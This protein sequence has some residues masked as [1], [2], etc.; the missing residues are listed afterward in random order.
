MRL[1]HDRND[2]PTL[3]KL[4]YVKELTSGVNPKRSRHS[5]L[6]HARENATMPKPLLTLLHVED[7]DGDAKFVQRAFAKE[8]EKDGCEITRVGSLSAAIQKLKKMSFDAILLD[9]NLNDIKGLSNVR[10]IKEENAEL[11]IVVLSGYDDNETALS[12]VRQGAQEYMVKGHSNSRMLGLAVLSSIERKIYERHLFKQANH[13]ELTGLPNRRMFLEYMERGIIRANRWKRIE[14]LMFLDV[15]GFKNVNDTLGHDIG[16]RLLE[17]IAARLKVGLRASDML[18][19][20]GGDEFVVHLDADAH[21]S[22]ETC[23][24]VAEKIIAM[25][26][27][28][29]SAGNHDIRTG[30]SIGIAF[31][32]EHGKDIAELIKSADH[33]MYQAKK[34]DAHIAFA[35]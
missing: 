12:A 5:I 9:L 21:T 27:D 18:A 8:F 3:R 10:A 26:N 29:I 19:R 13:D 23:T 15:N 7:D 22:K 30:V 6:L 2:L 31:Y 24:H 16:D 11:P 14:T 25:F 34:S 28:P 20:Y 32:P 35:G 33:A 17:K 4:L 1:A